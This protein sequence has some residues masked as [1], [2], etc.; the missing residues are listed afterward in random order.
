MQRPDIGDLIICNDLL[1][2]ITASEGSMWIVT[3]SDDTKV[4]INK[5]ANIQIVS[6]SYALATLYYKKLLSKNKSV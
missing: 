5:T 2:M 4:Q 3:P 6:N 1:G